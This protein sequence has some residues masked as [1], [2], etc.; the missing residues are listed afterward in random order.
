M[1][2]PRLDYSKA[3]APTLGNPGSLTLGKPSA[4]PEAAL[5]KGPHE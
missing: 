3:V 5:R 1:S 2:F 4:M